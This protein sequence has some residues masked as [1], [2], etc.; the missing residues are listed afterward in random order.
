M[1]R[2]QVISWMCRWKNYSDAKTN[3]YH[4]HREDIVTVVTMVTNVDF[5]PKESSL[6]WLHHVYTEKQDSQLELLMK[7][8]T[9][10]FLCEMSR[11]CPRHLRKTLI[12]KVALETYGIACSRD[13][14]EGHAT[15]RKVV[16]SIKKLLK[17]CTWRMWPSQIKDLFGPG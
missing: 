2:S 5:P 1:P 12:S 9:V 11:M 13:I 6:W 8:L 3:K 16:N 14:H 17:K 7:L 15:K 4:Y 10:Y